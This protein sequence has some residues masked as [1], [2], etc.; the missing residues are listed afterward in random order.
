MSKTWLIG[1]LAVAMATTIVPAPRISTENPKVLYGAAIYKAMIGDA[2]SAL[3]LLQRSKTAATPEVPNPRAASPRH[4][5][6][7]RG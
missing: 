2:G 3:R 1:G 4:F 6:P 7:Q 5:S